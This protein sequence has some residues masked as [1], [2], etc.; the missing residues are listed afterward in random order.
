MLTAMNVAFWSYNFFFWQVGAGGSYRN[1]HEKDG[2]GSFD[3]KG[4]R[5]RDHHRPRPH[6]VRV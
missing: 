6:Q 5:R 1:V 2:R 4:S 3:E